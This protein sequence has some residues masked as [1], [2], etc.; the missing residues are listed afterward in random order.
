MAILHESP[1]Q[2]CHLTLF[3]IES[4]ASS[5]Q[6]EKGSLTLKSCQVSCMDFDFNFYTEPR[7]PYY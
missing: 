4:H 1:Q 3:R 7:W 2:P 6:L 5:A